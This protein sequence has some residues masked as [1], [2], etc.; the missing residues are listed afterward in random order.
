MRLWIGDEKE[1]NFKGVKTLF[2]GSSTITNRDIK[3]A[4]DEYDTIKQLYF[5]AGRCSKI[6][7]GVVKECIDW[8][9]GNITL[10][11]DIKKLHLYDLNLRD[12]VHYIIT[13]NHPNIG[14]LKRLD[15]TIYFNNQVKLQNVN[16]TDEALYV[17]SLYIGDRHELDTLEGKVYK[18][19][20]ILK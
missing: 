18:G 14:L 12:K 6:N 5:G 3:E 1:G 2:I 9:N 15:N 17:T 20:I 13:I 8:F 10:E 7:E 16:G 11:V 19:D 4:V